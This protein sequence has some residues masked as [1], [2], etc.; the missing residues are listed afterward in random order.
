ME[1][2][3]KANAGQEVEYVAVNLDRMES[4]AQNYVLKSGIQIPV[5]WD[6]GYPDSG[7]A[8]EYGVRRIPE[9]VVI[10]RLGRISGRDVQP[11]QLAAMLE[12]LTRKE[13]YPEIRKGIR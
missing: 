1:T 13:E 4:F 12:R 7:I 11:E 3:R 2:F 9:I 5:I 10:D 6:N 8:M